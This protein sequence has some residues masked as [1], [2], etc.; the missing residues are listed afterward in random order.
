MGDGEQSRLFAHPG[1]DLFAQVFFRL[2]A[3]ADIPDD[4]QQA[5]PAPI[6]DHRSAD[7]D[8]KRRAIPAHMDD[9]RFEH[10]AR[11]SRPDLLLEQGMAFRKHE[12]RRVQPYEFLAGVAVHLTRG[13]VGFHYGVHALYH[14]S[15]TRRLRLQ[16]CFGTLLPKLTGHQELNSLHGCLFR[17]FLLLSDFVDP[18]A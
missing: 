11:F 16:K 13:R 9:E 12:D 1:F 17:G 8:V 4:A 6:I 5:R 7:F 15:P 10:A 18:V 2:D 14:R 3:L